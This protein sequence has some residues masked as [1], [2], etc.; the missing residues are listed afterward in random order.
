MERFE[1]IR[2]NGLDGALREAIVIRD[3]VT[4][5]NYLCVWGVDG[6][7]GLTALVDKDGK[8]AVT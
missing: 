4:G 5:V 8:P 7:S 1:I 6:R 3:R 2:E